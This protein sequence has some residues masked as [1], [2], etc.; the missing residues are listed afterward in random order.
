MRPKV[1]YRSNALRPNPA[2][3]TTLNSLGITTVYDLRTTV[4][5]NQKP[6]I[7]PSGAKY[8]RHNI[9]GDNL[10]PGTANLANLKTPQQARDL[11]IQAN[12]QFVTHADERAQIAAAITDIVNTQRPQ[13]IH[14]TSGKDRT[15]WVAA[16]IRTLIG[17]DQRTVFR[18]YLLTNQYSAKSIDAAAARAAQQSGPELGEA[19]RVVSGVFPEALQAGIDAANTNYG[20]VDGYARNGL[21]LSN[22]TI[23]KLKAKLLV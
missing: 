5:I 15:G 3:L 4:E 10:P 19:V 9:V 14:C 17:V 21:G 18:D 16:V 23:A 13:L 20:S 11:L 22:D 7:L 6:D 8:V 12:Q 2:D 1:L